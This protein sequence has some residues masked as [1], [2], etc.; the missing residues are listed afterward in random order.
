MSQVANKKPMKDYKRGIFVS[1]CTSLSAAFI[2][3]LLIGYI[4]LDHN[5]MGEFAEYNHL[6]GQKTIQWNNLLPLTGIWFAMVFAICL[7]ACSFVFFITHC[8]SSS[9][10]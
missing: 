2:V 9:E 8:F 4:A 6:T 10:N 1:I 3:S 7:V 5:P